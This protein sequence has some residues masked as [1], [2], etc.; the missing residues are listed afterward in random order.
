MAIEDFFDH[1]ADIY[2]ITHEQRGPGFGLPATAVFS[3]PKTPDLEEQPCHFGVKSRTWNV[4][5]AEP[6]ANLEARIKVTFPAGTDVRLND[7]IIDCDSGLQYTAEQPQNIRNHH[8]IVWCK[9]TEVQ[10]PL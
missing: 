9:R 4:V 3:Y 1:R 6:Q 5:Q 10:K 7:K 8:T 2:H